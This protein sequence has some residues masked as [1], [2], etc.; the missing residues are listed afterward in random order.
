M[1]ATGRKQ[2]VQR[3]LEPRTELENVFVDGVMCANEKRMIVTRHVLSDQGTVAHVIHGVAPTFVAIG[4]RAR[5]N[6]RFAVHLIRV[7]AH[8]PA[9]DS[10]QRGRAGP[11]LSVIPGHAIRRRSGD[12]NVALEPQRERTR[13]PILAFRQSRSPSR[14]GPRRRCPHRSN[15]RCPRAGCHRHLLRLQTSHPRLNLRPLRWASPGRSSCCSHR[16]AR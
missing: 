11:A 5:R 15:H 7:L 8:V 16:P 1:I 10:S 9:T 14:L 4:T 2:P 6:S 3:D 13:S 12:E